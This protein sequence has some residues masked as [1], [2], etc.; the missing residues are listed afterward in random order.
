ME[1]P[2]FKPADHLIEIGGGK[3]Y[4][5]VADRILWFRSDCPE[6]TI[7][8][9]AIHIDEKMALFKATVANGRGALATGWGQETP[10]HFDEYVL[11]AETKA[12]GRA[13]A[14]LGYG[15]QYAGSE[16]AMDNPDGSPH[17]VDSPVAKV[18]L[19]GV[20]FVPKEQM[21]ATAR[22]QRQRREEEARREMAATS[23]PSLLKA[24]D[25]QVKFIF[26]IAREAGLDEQELATWCDELYG[27]GVSELNRRDASS[28][29]EALQR[30]RNEIA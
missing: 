14:A 25:R 29:I 21:P 11:K 10:D 26:A 20:Q 5:Q 12:V 23:D 15:T 18:E 24:T 1:F 17:V 3:L 9:E 4:M 7:N 30:R 28:L 16:L 27:H 19:S 6:G 13:L 8:T 22:Q 2:E